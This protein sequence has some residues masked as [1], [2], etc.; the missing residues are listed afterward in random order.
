MRRDR[1]QAAAAGRRHDRAF[2]LHALARLGIVRGRNE[3]LVAGAHLQRERALARLGQHR[4]GLE[5]MPDLAA[6]PEPVEPAR[7]KYDRIEPP[8][9]PL[10]EPRVDV[11]P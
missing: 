9:A 4:L 10:A 6:E 2:R 8:L 3:L 7:G 5:P 1:S 11:A